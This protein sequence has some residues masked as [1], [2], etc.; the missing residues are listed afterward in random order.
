M[1]SQQFFFLPS[2]IHVHH[3]SQCTELRCYA[4]FLKTAGFLLIHS[5][6]TKLFILFFYCR[7]I[8]SSLYNRRY[9]TEGMLQD[10]HLCSMCWNS[11]KT[12]HRQ[13]LGALC[14]VVELHK[15]AASVSDILLYNCATM[16]TQRA[17]LENLDP[18]SELYK[19]QIVN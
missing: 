12:Q 19:N 16:L 18:D 15:V 17:R 3:I 2:T 14:L 9:P 10:Y 1:A 7:K 11:W 6:I 5:T 8:F 13:Q 4:E